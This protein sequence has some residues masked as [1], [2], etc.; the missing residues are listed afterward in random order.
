MDHLFLNCQFAKNCW[1]L[2]GIT[3]QSGSD[4]LEAVMQIKDQT[5]PNFFLLAS[6]LM[7][8]GIWTAR[9]ELIFNGIQPSVESV[10]GNFKKEMNI[11]SLR[12][13]ARFTHT[14]DLWIQ[15]LL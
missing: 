8:W 3:I 9:N 12:A 13:K 7:C 6:I 15:N 5:H 4:I 2:L 14:F 11:L 1:S 10:N